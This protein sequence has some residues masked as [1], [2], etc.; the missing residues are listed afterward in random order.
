MNDLHWILMSCDSKQNIYLL[1]NQFKLHMDK[2]YSF[3]MC[4]LYNDNNNNQ[5]VEG[6]FG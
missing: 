5:I 6:Y 1:R 3:S 4:T 2:V